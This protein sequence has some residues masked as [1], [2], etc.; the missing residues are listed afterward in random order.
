VIVLA[1]LLLGLSGESLSAFPN[2]I[3]F[4][5]TAAGG[6]AGGF[7]LLGDS[8]L[9][10][11]QDLPMLVEW[12]KRNPEKA[13]FVSYFGL[14]DPA[15]YGL[16]YVPL[17]GGYRYDPKPFFPDRPCVLAVSATYL[18]GLYVDP[19][20]YAQFYKPLARKQPI[21]ILGGSIYL[22]AYPEVLGKTGKENSP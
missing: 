12:Q 1:A 18:Q 10:W 17:P 7:H 8:N 22:F 19:Q 20:L 16:K 11:G 5:N 15:Y 3:P 21:E 14:A 6:S 13:L 2:F 9:D 4:F